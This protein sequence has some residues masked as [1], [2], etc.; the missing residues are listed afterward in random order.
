MTE[1]DGVWQVERA[2]GALPPLVGVRKSIRGGRGETI[3]GP[4]RLPF[5]VE[6]LTLRYER[7]FAALVDV[8]EPVGDGFRGRATLAGR[9]YGTF[10]M[11][12]VAMDVKD[13]LKRHLDEAV[14]MEQNVKRMLDGMIGSTDEPQMLDALEHHRAE[15]EQHE[16]MMRE[17]LEAN[18]GTP[19][20]VRELGGML[21]ALVKM[22]LDMVRSERT[23]RNARDGY[24]T[25]H[26]EIASYE[27][28]KRVAQRAG[29]MATVQACDTIIGQERAMAG[30]IEESWD[31]AVDASLREAGVPVG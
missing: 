26:M 30:R 12:R 13:E 29:D 31:V 2:G 14:A 15:T 23:G 21:G 25:E 17:R 3:A 20:T 6:A 1:L 8:L 11:R 19:S 4:L 10:T 27:L 18:G 16:R 28:L 24:A 7:P 9:P 5:R 22:P